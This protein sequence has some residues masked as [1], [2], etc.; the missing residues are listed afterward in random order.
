[1][2][3][4]S[5]DIEFAWGPSSGGRISTLSSLEFAVVAGE[6]GR[7][8]LWICDARIEDCSPTESAKATASSE[9]PGFAA[10]AVLAGSAWKPRADDPHPWIEIDSIATRA[11]GGVIVDWLEHAP[12]S[13]FRVRASNTGRRWKTLYAAAAA[14]GSRSYVYLPGLKTR[15]LRLELDEPSAGAALRVQSFEF[16]RSIH[17]FWNNVANGEARG[18]HPRWLHNQQ[19]LWTPFGT[20]N[21][22]RCAL[23]N[24]DGMAEIDQ[25]SFSIEP[26]LWIDGRLYTWAD[27]TPRQELLDDWMPVPSV[28]WET[29]DWR[30]SVQGESTPSGASR[31]SYRFENR[32][33]RELSARL[34]L[35]V[36]P[37]QVTPPWQSFRDVGG[38]SRIH[39]LAWRDGAVRVDGNR[40]IVPAF[41]DERIADMGFGALRFD[42]G[43]MAAHLTDGR[44]PVRAEA[45]DPFGFATGALGFELSPRADQTLEIRL[46]C[47]N[48][49]AA[50]SAGEPVF[51]WSKTVNAAQWRGA[52]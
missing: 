33:D 49:A 20:A 52:G 29:G 47:M 8:T 38:V 40:L 12:A 31:L 3:V 15:F 42:D 45:Q 37:F 4:A 13:G 41:A 18:W 16:S 46:D 48:A 1:M 22:V 2:T 50:R 30:L 39:E 19:S 11:T 9:L 26:M 28:I 44:L 21:G 35:L 43:F 25:G 5:S 7:G 51:D 34:F 27:V 23:M 14:G 6:G 17:A 36:R 24:H 10:S 32:T